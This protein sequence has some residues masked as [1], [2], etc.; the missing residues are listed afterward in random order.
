[1][2]HIK[3]FTESVTEYYYEINEPKWNSDQS[4]RITFNKKD[5]DTITSVLD[6]N[7][8]SVFGK[9]L[10]YGWKKWN[11]FEFKE[12]YYMMDCFNLRF[13]DWERIVGNRQ[14]V[15]MNISKLNDEWYTTRIIYH[16]R[17]NVQTIGSGMA[18]HISIEEKYCRC[19][20]LEGLL[21]L[22]G[23]ENLL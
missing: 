18:N 16:K 21:K 22:L 11:D 8:L 14:I 6:L 13:P 19:D 5:V 3:K 2:K 20:Q 15:L 1:M 12:K 23:D 4:E 7:V 10:P 17:N 9:E